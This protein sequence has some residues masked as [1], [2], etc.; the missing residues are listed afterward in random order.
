M[1]KSVEVLGKG[2]EQWQEPFGY[3]PL[4]AEA[5]TDR[6]Y[7]TAP[8]IKALRTEARGPKWMK[9]LLLFR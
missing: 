3:R 1:T 5:F 6:S 8:A 4:L 7:M 2:S 9:G